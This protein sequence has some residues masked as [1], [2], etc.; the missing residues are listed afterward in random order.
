MATHNRLGESGEQKARAYLQEKGY[1]ILHTN[2]RFGHKEIDIVAKKRA[3][4]IFVEVKTRMSGG[5]ELPEK[6]I[7]NSKIKYLLEAAQHYVEKYEREEEVRF[8]VVAI[9]FENGDWKLNH[10]VDAFNAMEL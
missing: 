8:D 3:F 2:W 5:S 1:E 4:L 6:T 9:V 7:T 10:I